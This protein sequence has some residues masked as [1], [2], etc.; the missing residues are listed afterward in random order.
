[1]TKIHAKK[2]IRSVFKIEFQL[3]NMGAGRNLDGA[4]NLLK[5]ILDANIITKE[6]ARLEI[7]YAYGKVNYK[8]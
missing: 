7:A 4:N 1:M 6:E 5:S 3:E 2:L 8:K